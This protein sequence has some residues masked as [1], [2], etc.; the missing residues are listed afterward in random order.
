MPGATF[1]L[2][3]YV[4]DRAGYGDARFQQ[5]GKGTALY[6]GLKH[7]G[8]SVGIIVVGVV[9]A[10]A[11]SAP[12]LGIL[13]G[14]VGYIWMLIGFVYYRVYAF[15][16]MMRER[17]LDGVVTFDAEAETGR[18]ITIAVI[19]SLVMFAASIGA[20]A[21]IGIA[22]FALGM[23]GGFEPGNMG[24]FGAILVGGVTVLTYFALILLFGAINLVMITQKVIAHVVGSVTVANAPHLDQIRQRAAATDVDADGFADA[25]DIGGAI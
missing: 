25:L 4:V 2:E 11:L 13:A 21:I 3:K 5:G 9:L 19:G 22:G 6:P 14:V 20:G 17:V 18:V 23:F 7:V 8:I 16:Y 24:M 12:G 15:N 1:Y 10:A